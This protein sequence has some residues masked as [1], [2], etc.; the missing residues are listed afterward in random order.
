[1]KFKI[2]I[3]IIIAGLIIAIIPGELSAAKTSYG[4]ALTAEPVNFLLNNIFNIKYEQKLSNTNSFTAGAVLVSRSLSGGSWFGMGVNGSYRWYFDLFKTRKK[5]LQGF[6]VGPRASILYLSFDNDKNFAALDG[7]TL[8]VIGG[9]AMYKWIW[10]SFVLET[11]IVLD[12]PII[13]GGDFTYDPFGINVSL[14][15]AW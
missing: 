9:E 2:S 15:Y 3:L 5:L 1:M 7:G 10:D 12:F 14:G 6:S 11:G 13:G 8:F 4:E